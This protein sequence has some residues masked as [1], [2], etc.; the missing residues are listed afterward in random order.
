M[1]IKKIRSSLKTKMLLQIILILITTS[2]II[3]F[4]AVNTTKKSIEDTVGNTALS[5]LK[6]IITEID[7]EKFVNIKNP[8]DIDTPYYK[9]THEK[10]SAAMKLLGI[11]YLYTMR[12]ADNG[13]LEYVIDGTDSESEDFSSPGDVE[14]ETSEIMN[15][16]MINGNPG[17]EFSYTERWGELI[18]AYLPF[19]N[20]EGEIIGMIAA[21]F[22]AN[23]ASKNINMVI[24]NIVVVVVIILIFST[25]F[26]YLILSRIARNIKKLTD[27]ISFLADGDFTKSINIKSID[28]LGNAGIMFNNAVS[29]LRSIINT[30]RESSME[31]TA[32]SQELS[33]NAQVTHQSINDVADSIQSVAQNLNMQTESFKIM[34]S[35]T[36]DMLSDM[37]KISLDIKDSNDSAA[38]SLELA[39]VGNKVVEQAVSQILIISNQVEIAAQEIN[40]LSDKSKEIES[41]ITTIANISSQINLLSLNA[42]IEAAR[43]GEHGRGFAVVA[44]E[45]GKLAEASKIATLAIS[46]LINEIQFGVDNS[47]DAMKQSTLSTQEGKRHIEETG[48]AFKNI[49]SS[50][51]SVSN[52]SKSVYDSIHNILEE[53]KNIKFIISETNNLCASNDTSAQTVSAATQEQTAIIDEIA[54]ASHNLTK[55]AE[56]LSYDVNSFIT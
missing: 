15:L 23:D 48:E 7:V 4:M 34:N 51:E 12:K 45:V 49:S 35:S 11:E 28:E 52:L 10:F 1:L 43:A 30:I 46:K 6:Q 54:S 9:E 41:I 25:L 32:N 19:K 21:D 5:I 20:S 37:E 40:N 38:K 17:Y 8:S 16:T 53:T 24:K 27:G 39:K 2:T 36:I 3:T 18:S 47:V 29:K 31:L 33:S 55:M 26:A 50:V 22:Q 44:D 13:K 14:E 56:K 42:A